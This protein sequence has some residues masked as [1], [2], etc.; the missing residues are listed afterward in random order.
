MI[1]SEEFRYQ[2][3]KSL[4]FCLAVLAT[5]FLFFACS[6]G[7]SDVDGDPNA[8]QNKE[9]TGQAVSPKKS[10]SALAKLNHTEGNV[11]VVID[12][13]EWNASLG[14]SVR[15]IF[16]QD[17]Y[18]L[19]QAEPMFKITRI[20]PVDFSGIFKKYYSILVVANVNNKSPSGTYMRSLLGPKNVESARNEK[21]DAPPFYVN[22]DVFTPGQRIVYV[23]A[24]SDEK[25]KQKIGENRL[26]IASYF[27]TKVNSL[28][29]INQG[30]QKYDSKLTKKVKEQFG[31][32]FKVPYGYSLA[33]EGDRFLWL[34]IP[35]EEVDRNIII[36]KMPYANQD[37]F[38]DKFLSEWRDSLGF[39]L[40]KV[41]GDTNH[42]MMTQEYMP[43]KG[44]EI[45]KD[46]K[47]AKL[48][49]GLWKLKDNT[50]GGPFV[51]YAMLSEDGTEIYYVEGFIAA[52]GKSKRSKIREMRAILSNF[53]G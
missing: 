25:L 46:G 44:Q 1:L 35:D 33:K 23:L 6:G 16:L 50:L 22:S 27:D 10:N 12:T 29:S 38:S 26:K 53:K 47:Y 17:L 14:D 2:S 52:P 7:Q 32:T 37:Q 40:V 19:P 34:R 51:S 36:S 49:R 3:K 39:R 43:L 13:S 15:R 21:K 20:D 45:T 41:E 9:G 24:D 11:L 8:T 42:Y 48:C 30:Y 31:A 5:S 18:G 4:F 28:M